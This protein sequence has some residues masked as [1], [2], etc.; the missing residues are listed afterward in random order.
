ME[1]HDT[2]FTPYRF[3]NRFGQIDPEMMAEY[4]NYVRDYARLR[5]VDW[6]LGN[7]LGSTDN[8][9]QQD[10]LLEYFGSLQAPIELLYDA[11][12][13]WADANVGDVIDLLKE[14]G[15]WDQAIFIFLSDHGE[16][17]GEHGGWSHAQSVYEE[18]AHVP[19]I[20]HFPGGEFAGQRITAPVSLVDVMPTIFDYLGA[21]ESCEGCRGKS[22]MPWLRNTGERSGASATVPIMRLNR[23]NYYRPW[24]ESRGDVNV[25][26][27]RDNWKGVWNDELESLELYDLAVDPA[28]Q[29]DVSLEHPKLVS[30]LGK[31][32][33]NWLD[34]CRSFAQPAEAAED[35]DEETR[36]K[37]KALGYFN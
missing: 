36:E 6:K 14:R 30:S 18:L 25:A 27:R 15:V 28:E 34:T 7:P 11:A 3:I 5:H 24:K 33:Q 26:V 23:I 21:S 31:A 29:T 8:T 12:T 32:A 22:L 35:I 13:L 19:L 37:L 17:L 20:I 4:P 2:Y 9:E 16:E 10:E 1:L